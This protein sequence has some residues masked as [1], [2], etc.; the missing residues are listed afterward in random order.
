MTDL[1]EQ[2]TTSSVL[3]LC[4]FHWETFLSKSIQSYFQGKQYWS[5]LDRG[6]LSSLLINLIVLSK[7]KYKWVPIAQTIPLFLCLL[8]QKEIL[9]KFCILKISWSVNFNW[10]DINYRQL[11]DGLL[12][13][14][15]IHTQSI[16]NTP[17]QPNLSQF[18]L[19]HV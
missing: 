4:N 16:I 3:G 15:F 10:S 18:S 13:P 12:K 8:C 14:E 11:K 19:Q 9:P 17:D 5:R 7:L 6:H 1:I 2:K